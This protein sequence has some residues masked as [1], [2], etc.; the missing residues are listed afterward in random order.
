MCLVLAG[1]WR[2]LAPPHAVRGRGVD[3]VPVAARDQRG[4]RAAP[5]AGGAPAA[6]LVDE[7][8]PARRRALEE[9]RAPIPAP[10]PPA[11]DRR[12]PP[13]AHSSRRIPSPLAVPRPRRSH[14][15]ARRASAP[16]LRA[17]PRRFRRAESSSPNC[18]SLGDQSIALIRS[19]LVAPAVARSRQRPRPPSIVRA[20]PRRCVAAALDSCSKRD[21]CP[22]TRRLRAATCQ[23]G[24][25][26]APKRAPDTQRGE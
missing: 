21:R 1:P 11:L 2:E 25:A 6:R 26:R 23:E 14:N 5:A 10:M 9:C 7:R 22:L 13:R 19:S 4:E 8:R 20:R 3:G 18:R 24:S 17:K 15:P 12:Q 16:V